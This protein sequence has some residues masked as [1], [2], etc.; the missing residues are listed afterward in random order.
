MSAAAQTPAFDPR[1]WRDQHIGK[2]TE[3]LTIGS[4]HL[5]QMP[6]G[7]K[8]TRDMLDPLLAKL[9]AFK[10]DIITHEGRSGEQCE[11]LR[12]YKTRYPDMWSTYCFGTDDAEKATGLDVPE[13]M[14][15]IEQTL[16]TWPAQPT[17][18]QRRKL[19]ST[20]LAAGDRLS[21]QVQW[22]QLPVAERKTG[23]GIDAALLKILLREEL[24]LNE[25]YDIAVRLAAQIG[26]QRV[27]AV[28]DHTADS[29][30]G[31]AG[32]GFGPA[33]EK[34]WSSSKFPESVEYDS[35]EKGIKD[36]TTMLN[37]YRF[38]NTPRIQRA[39]IKGDYHWAMSR[40]S[41]ELY[42]RQYV[43]WWETRNLRMVAN[44]RAAFGNRPGARVLNI[45]GSSHKPYYDRT[46]PITMLIS[47]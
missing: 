9:A 38:M 23:E 33:L 5:G 16:K 42:G 1:S 45:V 11:Q 19:A 27:Y 41:P 20:F 40:P 13:A 39:F 2:P 25:V 43:A 15:A 8:I 30:Q 18:A 26:L 7:V 35:R 24:P 14:V 32:P 6:D 36:G 17:A 3:V 47:T 31:Y 12:Q 29:I 28:D 46:N 4:A 44:V 34:I 21:A 22:L 10:P 37:L